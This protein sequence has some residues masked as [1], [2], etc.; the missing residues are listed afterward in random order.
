MT[1][2]T[3]LVAAS[4]GSATEG[5]I[6]LACRLTAQLGAHVEAYHVLVDPVAVF[7]A[8]GAGDGVAVSQSYIDAMSAHAEATASKVEA[9]FGAT[10]K[11][12]GLVLRDAPQ[13]AG[14]SIEGPSYCW[15]SDRGHAPSLV[16]QR[17]RF[18]DLA[19]LGRSERAISEPSTDTVEETLRKS[20]RPVLLAPSAAPTAL[21]R[22][23][24]FGWNG[25]DESV[26]ALATALPILARAEKV[27]AITVGEEADA[28]ELIAYLAWHGVAAQHRNVPLGSGDGVG[29]TLLGAAHEVGA[30]LLVMGGYGQRPCRQMLFGGVTREVVGADTKLPLL[31]VH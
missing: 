23:V 13:S 3:V 25:S 30:D 19:V 2:R 1:I 14:S 29:K 20:G 9:A 12:H 16:A 7:M 31:L 18:F 5:A 11:R 28:A 26:R 21:G 4:G 22:S 24:A 27:T 10:A 17:A 15:R 8:L 6:E